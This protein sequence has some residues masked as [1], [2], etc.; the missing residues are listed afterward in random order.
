MT[1]NS[2][3]L[4]LVGA[5]VLLFVL[6]GGIAAVIIRFKQSIQKHN[7][8]LNLMDMNDDASLHNYDD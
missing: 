2:S 3:A 1:D 8:Q 5:I 7:E 4:A 6:V